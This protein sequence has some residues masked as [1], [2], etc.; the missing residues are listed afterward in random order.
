MHSTVSRWLIGLLL[1]LVPCAAQSKVVY[2]NKNAS[3]ATHDGATWATAFLT[4][5]EGVTAAASGDEVWVAAS[6]PA[7]PAYIENIMPTMNVSL[8][9]GFNGTESD[10]AQRDWNANVTILD[11]NQTGSVLRG[12]VTTVDGFTIRNGKAFVGGGMEIFGSSTIS[13]NVITANSADMMGVVVVTGFATVTNC[14]IAGN[15]GTALYTDADSVLTNNTI[16]GNKGS[17]LSAFWGT[18]TVYNTI[19]AFNDDGLVCSSFS[20]YV[21]VTAQPDS[22]GMR[23]RPSKTD[24]RAASREMLCFLR[25]AM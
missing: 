18:S 7:A 4:V 1:V 13:H 16:V 9:G 23:G 5:Q 6:T 19:I 21:L 3:G 11:G 8:Y 20:R 24:W 2:V 22:S 12:A 17:G 15:T 10:R 25:V 14:V